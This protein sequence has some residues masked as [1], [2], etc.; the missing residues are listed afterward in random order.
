M[1]QVCAHTLTQREA[2]RTLALVTLGV[3]DQTE[4]ATDRIKNCTDR[5]AA[6]YVQ[7]NL[8]N[9]ALRNTSVALVARMTDAY[10]L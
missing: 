7:L 4:S 2:Q 8:I 6:I 5:R 3:S 9:A 10:G 1:L